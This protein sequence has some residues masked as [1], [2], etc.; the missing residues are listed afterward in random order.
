[1]ADVLVH[2]SACQ[3]RFNIKLIEHHTGRRIIWQGSLAILERHKP[4]AFRLPTSISP[5]DEPP[6]RAA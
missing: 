1:M 5:L 2:P 4:R 3:S 6:P